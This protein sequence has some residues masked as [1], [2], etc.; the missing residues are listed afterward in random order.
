MITKFEKRM[1]AFLLAGLLCVPVTAV[2]SVTA[3]AE[4]AES[5]VQQDEEQSGGE[6]VQTSAS[7]TQKDVE[8]KQPAADGQKEGNLS[9]EAGNDLSDGRFV[10]I[11]EEQDVK[12][13]E[14]TE[15]ENLKKSVPSPSGWTP[16]RTGYGSRRSCSSKPGWRRPSPI[17]TGSPRSCTARFWDREP[18]CG[19]SFRKAR[20][21][22]WQT[23]WNRACWTIWK[24]T[25]RT[26]GIPPA[27]SRPWT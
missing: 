16:P 22:C 27:A 20:A 21:C 17:L 9:S 1:L 14:D 3:S 18:C 25:T 12:E 2:P 4:E 26:S 23:G 6:D 15:K 8:E 19:L 10:P 5:T 13:S 7:E 11:E 24:S